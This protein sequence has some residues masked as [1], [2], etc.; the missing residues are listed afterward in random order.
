MKTRQVPT[1]RREGERRRLS[2]STVVEPVRQHV[3]NKEAD[4]EVGD[5]LESEDGEGQLALVKARDPDEE[6]V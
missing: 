4:E 6:Q 3:A 1:G 5:K 2:E